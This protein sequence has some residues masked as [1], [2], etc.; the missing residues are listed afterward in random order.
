VREI[1]SKWGVGG[2]TVQSFDP[3]TGDVAKLKKDMEE[4]GWALLTQT[5]SDD[6]KQKFQ[7]T[8]DRGTVGDFRHTARDYVE[9]F[10]DSL[11]LTFTDKQTVPWPAGA[12]ASMTMLT[13][14]TGPNGERPD[15]SKMFREVSLDDPFFQLL[16]VKLHV[17]CDFANDPIDTVV[18]QITYGDKTESFDFREKGT[19]HTF[20][21]FRD[22]AL[23]GRFSYQYTVH[24]KG[25]DKVLTSQPVQGLGDVL[26]VDVADMGFLKIDVTAGAVTWNL[27][28]SAEVQVRYSDAAN[29]VPLV[30]DAFVL[31][32]DATQHTYTR[33]IYAPAAQPYQYAVEFR[34][35]DSQ[36]ARLDWR[37]DRRS[38]LIIDD[39][40]TDHVAVRL[41]ASGNWDSMQRIV[42][43]LEYVDDA[44]AYH[45]QDTL[46]LR[47]D[48]DTPTWIAPVWS[49]GPTAFRYRQLVAYKDGR[50]DQGDW[51]QANG[52]QTILVGTIWPAFLTV[53][54]V[55]DLLD[56]TVVKLAKVALHYAD[57][58]HAI[59]E[60]EDM[61][62]TAA[63]P[64]Q[65]PWK[66]GIAEKTKNRYDFTATYYLADGTHRTQAVQGASDDTIVLQ[67]PPA[68]T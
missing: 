34:F 12:Q 66:L 19:I 32:S 53:S 41:L 62:F 42:V 55:T 38:T 31:K 27:I 21:T 58:D 59:D 52:S 20:R 44:H 9:A 16:Q 14:Q 29:G 6:M 48:A 22:K 24:Y 35:K 67:L 30:E 26:Q 8:T 17:N 36:R 28:D 39:V 15:L 60:A 45:K 10:S 54:C 4:Q 18:L 46:E 13:S 56:W 68:N 65:P 61:V 63:K 1:F 2:V 57:V 43:D 51:K 33:L 25:T 11:D 23:G 5:L 64:T 3:G 50:S 37:S 40:F 47:V 49:G 7:A